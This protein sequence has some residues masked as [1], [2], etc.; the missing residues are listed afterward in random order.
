MNKRLIYGHDPMC[1]WC[2][3]FADIYQTLT[4][5]LSHDMPIL[6]LL[7]G[8]ATDTDEPMPVSTQHML[9]RTWRRI[10]KVIPGKHFNYEFWTK[11]QP[12]RST[13]PACRAVIAAREQGAAYDIAMTQQIQQAYYQQARNPSDDDILIALAA[14]IGLDSDRFAAQLSAESTHQQLLDEISMAR[15]VDINSFPSLV[16]ELDGSLE[17]VLVNYTDADVM[18]AQI[19][20]S[21]QR[22][23][24]G[25]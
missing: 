4:T 19:E 3:G 24:A 18:L 11:C 6:R 8:L 13:Y 10:E 1:S 16:L 20:A 9:Q 15:S 2:W 23:K 25:Q 14:E 21:L 22:A 5:Q 7:G 17:P 12:R